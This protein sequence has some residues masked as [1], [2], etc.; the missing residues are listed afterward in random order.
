LAG[1]AGRLRNSAVAAGSPELAE[2][3]N[4]LFMACR[5]AT[6]LPERL[7]QSTVEPGEIIEDDED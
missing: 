3:W 7:E 4:L 5:E 2:V 6:E 1:T